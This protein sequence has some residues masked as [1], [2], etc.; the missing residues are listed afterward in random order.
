MLLIHVFVISEPFF[1]KTAWQFAPMLDIH[2]VPYWGQVSFYGGGGYVSDLEINLPVSRKVIQE[3][4]ENQWIDRQTRA[5]FLDFTVFNPFVN[6]FCWTNIVFEYLPEGGIMPTIT[7]KVFKLYFEDSIAGGLMVIAFFVFIVISMIIAVSFAVDLYRHGKL[8]LKTFTASVEGAL[9]IFS[10]AV[11]ALYFSMYF[12]AQKTLAAF[13]ANGRKYTQFNPV[14]ATY[15]LLRYMFGFLVF[16]AT[17]RLLLML[18]IMKN[19]RIFGRTLRSTLKPFAFFFLQFS[20]LYMA[21]SHLAHILF[22]RHLYGYMS[23]EKTLM[24]LIAFA[25]KQHSLSQML[26]TRP[27][28]GTIFYIT[29]VLVVSLGVMNIFIATIVHYHHQVRIYMERDRN[30]LQTAVRGEMKEIICEKWE[31]LKSKFKELQ[32]QMKAL[33]D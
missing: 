12:I 2:G 16:T 13:R 27:V 28:L 25:I 26:D 22:C 23:I 19:V 21:F 5:L 17:V 33:T 18:R 6:L 20:F 30:Y 7:N 14:V 1:T 32:K 8:H 29:Y 9:I 24:S 10:F 4:R 11:I 3:L 15:D 31:K